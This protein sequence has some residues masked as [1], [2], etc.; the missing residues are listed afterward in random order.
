M[1]SH[2]ASTARFAQKVIVLQDGKVVEQGTPDMLMQTGGVFA[3]LSHE[4]L[5][6]EKSN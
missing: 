1:A 3:R 6:S 2:R 5:E 4:Q